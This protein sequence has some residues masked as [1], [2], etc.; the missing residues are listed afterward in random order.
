MDNPEIKNKVD[1]YDMDAAITD[2]SS[3]IGDTAGILQ[4]LKKIKF[5]YLVQTCELYTRIDCPSIMMDVCDK[6]VRQ[7]VPQPKDIRTMEF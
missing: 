4:K 7:I 1:K 6:E 2:L 3:V 5:N